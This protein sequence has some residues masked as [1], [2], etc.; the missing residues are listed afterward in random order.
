M[1]KVLLIRWLNIL[2]DPARK[3]SSL[4]KTAKIATTA[5]T[6]IIRYRPSCRK[7]L[8]ADSV[9]KLSAASANFQKTEKCS[10]LINIY[11]EKPRKLG[12]DRILFWKI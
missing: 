1:Y 12:K 3:I 9:E 2:S 6:T 8:P 7:S 10:L 5:K 11:Q 4:K